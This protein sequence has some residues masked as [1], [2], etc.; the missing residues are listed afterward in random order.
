M[1]FKSVILEEMFKSVILEMSFKSVILED[2]SF[3]ECYFGDVS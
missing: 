2:K 3:K 1:S